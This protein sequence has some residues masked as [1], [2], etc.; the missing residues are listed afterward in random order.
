MKKIFYNQTEKRLKAGWRIL[1]FLIL[2]WLLASISFVIKPL[3][4][5]ITKREFVEGYSII[6][7]FILAIGAS[8]AVPLSRHYFDKKSFTS[9]GLKIN[10]KTIQDVVFGFLLSGLMASLFFS[11]MIIFGLVEFNGFNIGAA[12]TSE[13]Q[14]FDFVKF[15]K[16]FSIG[17]ATILF[18]EHILVG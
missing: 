4:G 5:D 9:L 13:G 6:I 3:L 1:L 2:F 15:M 16:I 10:N 14:P 17:S 11:L 12:T 8:I 7:V 18:V